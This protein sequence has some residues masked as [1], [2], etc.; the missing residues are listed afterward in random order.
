LGLFAARID[1][2]PAL[3]GELRLRRAK[4]L[5]YGIRAG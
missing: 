5:D 1:E 2:L 3:L 4:L